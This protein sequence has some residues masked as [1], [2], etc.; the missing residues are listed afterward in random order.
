MCWNRF[1]ESSEQRQCSN[2][3]SPFKAGAC[4]TSRLPNHPW[5][6]HHTEKQRNST[7]LRQSCPTA[8]GT[9]VPQVFQGDPQGLG[10]HAGAPSLRPH[11]PFHH[12]EGPGR[13]KPGH[14]RGWCGTQG[15]TDS[16]LCWA[17]HPVTSLGV[18]K[19]LG[20][21]LGFWQKAME[22]KSLGM[23]FKEKPH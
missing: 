23:V 8:V 18:Y 13:R 10:A 2:N 16:G 4:N 6:L 19:V 3:V 15:R 12:S 11:L 22:P 5:V 1:P 21:I 9:M 7:F 14:G 20:I 17:P